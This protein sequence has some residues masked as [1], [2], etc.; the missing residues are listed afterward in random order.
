M[1][2]WIQA[3]VRALG[4]QGINGTELALRAGISPR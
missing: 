2:T 3:I 4:A 1:G